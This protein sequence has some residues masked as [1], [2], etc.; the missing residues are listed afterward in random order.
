MQA[1]RNAVSGHTYTV[2]R[3]KGVVWYWRVR[4]PD[5]SEE[6]KAIG[7]EW[8]G[9]GRPPDGYFTK[10]TA[11]A[12]LDARLTDLRR[13][14]GL[15]TKTAVTFRDAAESWFTHGENDRDW[16]PSTRRDYRSAL[17]RHLLPEFGDKRLTEIDATMIE[18]WRKRLLEGTEADPRKLGRRQAVKLVSIMHGI[19]QR[20]RRVYKLPTLP[21]PAA[22]VE[23]L[24]VRYTPEDYDFYAP[25]EVLALV[26]AAASDQDGAIYLTAAYAGLRRGELIALR[27]RDI[28]FEAD[29]IHVM[30]SVDA[31]EGVGT[32]KS[33]KG[34]TVPMVPEV[35]QTLARLLQRERF[36]GSN[37]FLFPNEVGRYLDG[38]ALR[39][40]YKEAQK[41]AKLRPIKFHELRHTFGSLAIRQVGAFDVQHYL[42]HA[43]ARTT[44]RYTHYRARSGEAQK[45][46]EAFKIEQPDTDQANAHV[47]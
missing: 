18:T 14:L 6:R 8:D 45:L 7:P 24:R 32:P 10:R 20:A 47:K 41:T 35:A 26:R 19:Y 38:S 43:D 36:T 11:Q 33:G 22:E 5:G 42:G 44:A 39:R 9:P 46:A 30:G 21:N 15:P 4:L 37:D 1:K 12:A 34:R 17:D 3:R 31:K 29:A 2:K 23:P 27:V 40:R 25:E 13:G 28:D 16:K